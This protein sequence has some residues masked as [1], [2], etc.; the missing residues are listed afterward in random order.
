M[1][2]LKLRLH[3]SVAGYYLN[4]AVDRISRRVETPTQA[5]TLLRRQYATPESQEGLKHLF[6]YTRLLLFGVLVVVAVALATLSVPESQ[7]VL[8]L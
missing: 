1:I 4:V 6:I 7:E 5:S 2:A 3:T 8:E